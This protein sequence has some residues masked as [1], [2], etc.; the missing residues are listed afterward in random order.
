MSNLLRRSLLHDKKGERKGREWD[1]GRHEK[2]IKK[3]VRKKDCGR[4]ADEIYRLGEH[5]KGIKISKFTGTA[6]AWKKKT[7]GRSFFLIP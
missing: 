2:K 3:K 1:G 5:T 7:G 6:R 4:F